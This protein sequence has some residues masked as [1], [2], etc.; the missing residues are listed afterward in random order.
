MD[1]NRLIFL[2]NDDGFRAKGF[3]AA[4]EVASSFGDVIAI[5]PEFPQSGKSQAI[6]LDS[7]LQL[8][9][10]RDDGHVSVYSLSGTPVDCLKFAFDHMFRDR[11]FDLVISGINHGSNSAVNL[12]Y[13]GT[14]GA[15]IEGYF[16]GV[17]SIGLSLTDMSA[18]ADFS[19]AV[20]IGKDIVGKVLAASDIKP[21]CLNVNIPAIPFSEIRGILTCRQTRGFWIEDFVR[22]ELP[23]N[24]T[25][26]WV[27]GAFQNHEPDAEDTDEWALKHGYVAV[28]PVQTDMT[29]YSRMEELKSIL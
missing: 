25:C 3:E 12:M 29:A 7:S 15:A 2:T 18:D 22:Y 21:L 24:R 13:S 14:M 9:T 1:N 28:V 16:Y 4:I 8:N 10:I 6:T 20:T 26:Y 5:A 23:H 17:P 11:K 27:D 19:A